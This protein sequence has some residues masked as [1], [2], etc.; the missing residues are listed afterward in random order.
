MNLKQLKA[1]IEVPAVVSHVEVTESFDADGTR[2]E[3]VNVTVRYRVD[4]QDYEETLNFANGDLKE[5]DEVTVRNNPED[6]HKVSTPS[7]G[8]AVIYFIAAGVLALAGC[9]SFFGIFRRRV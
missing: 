9:G 8:N 6:P 1:Y 7:K 5:G 4:G 3:S 2:T